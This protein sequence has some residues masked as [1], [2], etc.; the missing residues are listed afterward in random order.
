MPRP[1][2]YS[3]THLQFTRNPQMLIYTQRYTYV[4]IAL[5]PVGSIDQIQLGNICG[6]HLHI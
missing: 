2:I 4:S 5:I 3:H 6:G 1:W